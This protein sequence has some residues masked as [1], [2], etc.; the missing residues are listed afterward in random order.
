[1]NDA[2]LG[3]KSVDHDLGPNR[4]DLDAVAVAFDIDLVELLVGRRAARTPARSTTT[5]VT[6]VPARL[7]IEISSSPPSARNSMRST[8][9]RLSWTSGSRNREAGPPLKVVLI[10]SLPAPL[11]KR[12]V[13]MPS[14]PSILSSPSPGS[15]RTGRCRRRARRGHCRRRRSPCRCPRRRPACHCRCRPR[16]SHCQRRRSANRGRR[17]R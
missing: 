4:R 9:S 7:L 6:S 11:M 12:T 5:A 17:C 13:S 14:P 16:A 1:M 15:T 2:D 8:W 10:P 3:G